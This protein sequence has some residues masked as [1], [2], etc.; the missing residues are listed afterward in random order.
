M[1]S[2]LP[3]WLSHFIL[4]ENHIILTKRGWGGVNWP[5]QGHSEDLVV[6]RLEAISLTLQYITGRTNTHDDALSAWGNESAPVGLRP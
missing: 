4:T 6:M 2:A 3:A 1:L 5:A